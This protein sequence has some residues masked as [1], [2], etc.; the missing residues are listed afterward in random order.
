[1]ALKDHR[2]GKPNA[3]AD[4]DPVK[5][6]ETY[7]DATLLRMR[8]AIDKKLNIDPRNLN[9]GEELGAQYRAGK[10]LLAHIQDD[11]S[12]PANQR[13]QVFN[14]VGAMLEKITKQMGVVFSAERLKRFEA[15]WMKVMLDLPEA[16]RKMYF[17]LYADYLTKE[18]T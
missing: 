4:A 9:M 13:A 12:V 6:I 15:A 18:E 2:L 17:D 3:A 14:S 7:D 8:N 1:M 11:D 16:S 10:A 5:A